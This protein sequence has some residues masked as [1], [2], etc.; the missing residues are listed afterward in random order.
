MGETHHPITT[1]EMKTSWWLS[2]NPFEKY[3]NVKMGEH[4]PQVSGWTFQ[5][6]LSCHHLI[7]KHHPPFLVG[8]ND[9][10]NF[11]KIA[12]LQSIMKLS[13]THQRVSSCTCGVLQAFWRPGN[14]FPRVSTPQEEKEEQ[15]LR[16]G[17]TKGNDRKWW[18]TFFGFVS[19][20][21]HDI[22][23]GSVPM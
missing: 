2:F 3:A 12:G 17:P 7:E 5:K 15:K 4:L 9:S 8:E 11:V 18:L 23:S 22:C 1:G 21:K 19:V 13:S 20:Y 16:E 6:Y 14:G 10:G